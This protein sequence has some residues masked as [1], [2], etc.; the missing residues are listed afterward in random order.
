MARDDTDIPEPARPTASPIDTNVRHQ[1][2]LER[3]GSS[4]SAKVRREAQRMIRETTRLLLNLDEQISELSTAELG[5]VL[6]EMKAAN[7]Q[8]MLDALGVLTPQLEALGVYD[9][10]FTARALAAA[11]RKVKIKALKAGAAYEAALKKPLSA[12]GALL[13]DFLTEW[14]KRQVT[15]VNELVGKAYTQGW[16][17]QQITTALRGTK[18][19]GYAD[20][21]V[22]K[23][24]SNADAVVR[25]AI[26]HV[27]STARTETWAKNADVVT[28][29]MFVATLDGDTC[30][31]CRPLDRTTYKIGE[32][33]VPP[34]HPRCR[35]TQAPEVSEEFDFLDKGA[36]RSA[37][38]GP[39]DARQTY[40]DWLKDQTSEFQNDAIGP[41]RAQLLRNGGL[42]AARFAKLNLGRNFEPLTLDEMRRK[43][44]SAFKR[45]GL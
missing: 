11:A 14:T 29:W 27:A 19:K 4:V 17:N 7:M 3:V 32:G 36:T 34:L 38:F 18:A 24:G 21:L 45:A 9:G 37:Q 22:S 15:A 25:T 35:C 13:D 42:S 28:G 16:T 26:Q 41:A 6:G 30:P 33:P 44:P 20:G 2:Y 39:V 8:C 40:Y 31:I 12:T 1:V 5:S 23:V 43:E 10:Q